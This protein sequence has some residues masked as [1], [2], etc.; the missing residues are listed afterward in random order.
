MDELQD[1]SVREEGAIVITGIDA[2]GAGFNPLTQESDLVLAGT[3]LFRF[4][5]HGALFCRDT[6]IEH[7]F[8]R[9]AGNDLV[10]SYKGFEVEDVIESA[11]IFA[12]LAVTAIAVRLENRTRL[13]R[14][15]GSG[16]GLWL[17]SFEN[18]PER[19]KASRIDETQGHTQ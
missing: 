6:F 2:S 15:L 18:P 3:K 8:V 10:A 19:Q 16:I 4:R 7:G 13:V 5:R 11:F 17:G 14:Q 12:V 1:V 9:F